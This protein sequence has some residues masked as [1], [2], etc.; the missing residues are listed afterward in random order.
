MHSWDG[1]CSSVQRTVE[2]VD[3]LRLKRSV[4][5]LKGESWRLWNGTG[6]SGEVM[7]I[8][9]EKTAGSV[10]TPIITL[11]PTPPKSHIRVIVV[12]SHLASPH[13]AP[14]STTRTRILLLSKYPHPRC[15]SSLVQPTAHYDFSLHAPVFCCPFLEGRGSTPPS[16]VT[17]SFFAWSV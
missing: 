15:T 10:R 5:H 14:P 7:V 17:L 13:F 11:P 16:L 9:H 6:G 12:L 3:C 4:W 2:V 8:G 1:L